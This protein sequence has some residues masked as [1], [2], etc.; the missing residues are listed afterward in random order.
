[1]V[2]GKIKA[3]GQ[4]RKNKNIWQTSLQIRFASLRRTRCIWYLLRPKPSA[5]HFPA[6]KCKDQ[7][8]NRITGPLCANRSRSQTFLRQP[9]NMLETPKNI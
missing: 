6:Q 9:E 2:G 7:V 1:M 8:R 3:V 5:V 4:S